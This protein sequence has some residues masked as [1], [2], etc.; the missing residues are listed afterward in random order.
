MRPMLRLKP[1][2]SMSFP[3]TSL[4]AASLGQ[5][6]RFS[7]PTERD[8]T[9]TRGCVRALAGACCEAAC[10]VGKDLASPACRHDVERG[11]GAVRLAARHFANAV[12]CPGRPDARREPGR[13]ARVPAAHVGNERDDLARVVQGR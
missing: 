6:V 4:T 10:D 13:C 3:T 9:G 5:R 11:E 8:T 2:N 7:L 12:A 1:Q